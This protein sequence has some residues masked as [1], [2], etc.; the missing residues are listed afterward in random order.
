MNIQKNFSAHCTT[1][2]LMLILSSVLFVSPSFAN[3]PTDSDI[4][5]WV[6]SALRN[7]ERVDASTVDVAVKD[8]VVTLSGEVTSLAE[9]AYAVRDA[10]KVRGVTDVVDELQ[11]VP[12]NEYLDSD[13]CHMVRRRILNSSLIHSNN[14]KVECARG[15]VTLSGEVPS[16]SER[17]AANLLTYEIGGVKDVENRIVVTGEPK[18]SDEEIKSRVTTL[19][20]LDVYLSGQPV[21]V[22]VKDGVVTLT[23]VV[24]SDYEKFIDE[25]KREYGQPDFDLEGHFKRRK[26][27]TVVLQKAFWFDITDVNKS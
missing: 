19:F 1:V 12:V 8:G 26:E 20:D 27:K 14:I 15:K 18:L 4:S 9:K 10:R 11:I 5:Y 21:T 22:S 6:K 13:I 3:T 7:D 2:F 23:G 24:E 25:Y 16:W 17:D